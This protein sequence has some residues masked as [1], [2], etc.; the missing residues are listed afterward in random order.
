MKGVK[1]VK[2][3]VKGSLHETGYQLYVNPHHHDFLAISNN[4]AS[5]GMFPTSIIDHQMLDYAKK[6]FDKL[7]PLFFRIFFWKIC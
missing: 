7:S 5:E 3:D 2:E 1:H 6:I 4:L